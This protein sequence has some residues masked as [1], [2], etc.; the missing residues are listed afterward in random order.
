MPAD[1]DDLTLLAEALAEYD[2]QEPRIQSMWEAVESNADVIAVE[3]AE[4]ERRHKVASAFFEVTKHVNVPWVVGVVSPGPAVSS[5]GFEENFIRR[6]VR[7]WVMKRRSLNLS[8]LHDRVGRKVILRSRASRVPQD[9]EVI[10][11]D[12]ASGPIVN[13]DFT[14]GTPGPGYFLYGAYSWETGLE[15]G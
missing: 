3:A 7:L 4:E 2:A 1:R 8:D 11:R 10:I 5:P 6:I 15:D 12:F 9:Q 14:D 13:V